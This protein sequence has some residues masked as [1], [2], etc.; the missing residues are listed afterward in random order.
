MATA[1]DDRRRYTGAAGL[2]RT[3]RSWTLVAVLLAVGVVVGGLGGLVLG[4][5]ARQYQASAEVSIL[6]DST[7]DSN[8]Y[9]NALQL[10]TSTYIQGELIRLNGKSFAIDVRDRLGLRHVPTFAF[11]QVDQTA[12]E[13]RINAERWYRFADTSSVQGFLDE[14]AASADEQDGA[15]VVQLAR[16]PGERE[17][18]W[19]HTLAGPVAAAVRV[20]AA[21]HSNGDST[22]PENWEGQYVTRTPDGAVIER[23]VDREKATAAQ[24]KDA[25]KRGGGSAW[26]PR[27]PRLS[28]SRSQSPLH[29]ESSLIGLRFA[30]RPDLI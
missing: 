26:G 3:R 30:V 8:L 27:R 23:D 5:G 4:G 11:A 12:G 9:P 10:D 20:G 18:R 13:L 6:P 15:L 25:W 22:A 24:H 7:V 29:H 28:G 1:A 19:A 21:P 16:G 14:L 2:E 17:T